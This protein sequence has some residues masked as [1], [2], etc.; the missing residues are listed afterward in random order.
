MSDTENWMIET[1]EPIM[2][3]PV[4]LLVSLAPVRKGG[5]VRADDPHAPH[6]L[7]GTRKTGARRAVV[8]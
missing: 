6:G 4:K 8:A 2:E 7:R 5:T 3:P 1:I